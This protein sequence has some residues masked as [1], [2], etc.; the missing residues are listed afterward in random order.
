MI[1]DINLAIQVRCVHCKR[2][3]YALNVMVVSRGIGGCS[4][5]GKKSKRM[6]VKEYRKALEAK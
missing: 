5:C 4:F 3:Q 2:E 1:L 6:T